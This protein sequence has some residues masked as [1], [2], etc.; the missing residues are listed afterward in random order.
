M[1]ML[2]PITS[3]PAPTA[4]DIAQIQ[5]ALTE[6]LTASSQTTQATN[7]ANNNSFLPAITQAAADSVLPS[8]PNGFSVVDSLLNI[9]TPTLSLFNEVGT[10]PT[11]PNLTGDFTTQ[12]LQEVGILKADAL[13]LEETANVSTPI[14]LTGAASTVD[15]SVQAQ[16]IANGAAPVT[17]LTAAQLGQIGAIL[18]PL[19][20]APLTPSLVLQ[21]Q[22]QLTASELSPLQFNLN[23]IQLVMSY[24]AGLQAAPIDAMNAAKMS[25]VANENVAIDAP[26]SAL[27]KVAVEDSAILGE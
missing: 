2:D 16:A 9:D 17:P 13:A 3:V 10:S 7:E 21:I 18:T 1:S 8:T 6:A 4:Q 15:L 12:Q 27:D 23:T 19:A 26:V 14:P 22:A 25:N 11:N 24:M 20:N 5:L